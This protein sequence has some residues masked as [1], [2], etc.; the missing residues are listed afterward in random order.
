[1][2]ISRTL[3]F[4]VAISISFWL[5][6]CA[7]FSYY[8]QAVNGQIEVLRK[9]Q[10]INSIVADPSADKAL[11]NTLS[12]VISLRK[13]ASRALKL[14]D[15]ESYMTYAD[16]K[17]PYVVWNVY[18]TPEFS[19]KLKEWCFVGAGCVEYRGFFSKE[20]AG[21]FADELRNKGYDVHVAGIRAY[22]TLGW[23]DDPVLNTFINFSEIQLARL[24]FHELSHQVVYVQDDTEFNESFATMVELEGTRRWLK[25]NGTSEQQDTFYASQRGELAFTKLVLKYQKKLNKLFS[26]DVNDSEK[27]IY[28]LNIFAELLREFSK[29]KATNKALSSY[30]KWFELQMNNALISTISTYTKHVPKF[31]SLLYQKGGDM[32]KFYSA[33]RD[34]GKLTKSDRYSSFQKR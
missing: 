34:I 5:Y 12:K 23:F 30:D 26:S 4:I 32:E 6:G 24:I 8:S 13:F 18:A 10:S 3:S 2:K 28:K 21:H 16:L 20:K 14:P 31:R 22:S 17:R 15:N 29:L 7:N 19:T 25:I 1:M 11:K 33:V 9:A 27:R